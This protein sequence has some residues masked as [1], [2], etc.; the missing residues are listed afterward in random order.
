MPLNSVYYVF[1]ITT[2]TEQK[3]AFRVKRNISKKLAKRKRKIE[4]QE[5]TET[6]RISPSR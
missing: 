1:A 2:T 4:K 5:K 3:G 6:G